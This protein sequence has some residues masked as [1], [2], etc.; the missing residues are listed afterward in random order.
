MKRSAALTPLSREHHQS[1][2]TAKRIL[3]ASMEGEEALQTYWHNI[4]KNMFPE[5]EHHFGEEE[6]A[7]GSLLE[8]KLKTRLL[9]EHQQLRSLMNTHDCEAMKQFAL[10]LRDHVRFEERE[11]FPWLEA[12]YSDLESQLNPRNAL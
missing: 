9:Q 11:L 2:L 6:E 5:L 10:C 3:D 8:D 1:L 12:N 7:F 4:R